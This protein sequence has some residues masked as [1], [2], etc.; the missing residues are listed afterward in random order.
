MV[1]GIVRHQD[2]LV[3][4][5]ADGLRLAVCPCGAVVFSEFGDCGV[6]LG[7]LVA[8]GFGAVVDRDVVL[9]VDLALGVKRLELVNL[10]FHFFGNFVVVAVIVMSPDYVVILLARRGVGLG[11]AVGV[12]LEVGQGFR[13]GGLVGAVEGPA[14]GGGEAGAL[15]GGGVVVVVIVAGVIVC[16]EQRSERSH[17]LPGLGS[18]RAVR[19]GGLGGHEEEGGADG[20]NL[21]DPADAAAAGGHDERFVGRRC[22]GLRVGGNGEKRRPGC[23]RLKN[24]DL[25]EMRVTDILHYH[26]R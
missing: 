20:G 12:C 11:L 13:H 6:E 22:R 8:V 1:A 23:Q 2:L 4:V 16:G 21:G 24:L 3:R 15:G 9:A 5:F 17:P 7:R 25:S 18:G 14:L 26:A 19:G 10:R